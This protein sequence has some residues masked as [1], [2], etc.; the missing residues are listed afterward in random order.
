MSASGCPSGSRNLY[1][2]TPPAPGG[3]RTRAAARDRL[4]RETLQARQGAG[5]V[6]RD[7][8]EVLVRDGG[9]RVAAIVVAGMALEADRRDQLDR[10][11]TE[12]QTGRAQ[13]RL[14][15]REVAMLGIGHRIASIAR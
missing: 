13:R 10:L 4:R 7:D 11:V 12:A 3:S 8:G 5:H 6:V 15:R 9:D 14:G 1:A 2:V